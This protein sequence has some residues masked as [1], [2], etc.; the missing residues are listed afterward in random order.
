MNIDTLLDFDSL[1]RDFNRNQSSFR[2]KNLENDFTISA[3]TLES[4]EF[5]KHFNLIIRD[6]PEVTYIVGITQKQLDNNFFSNVNE[7]YQMAII[8][9]NQSE[10]YSPPFNIEE[11]IKSQILESIMLI[12]S[13]MNIGHYDTLGCL[14]DFCSD[15][16]DIVVKLHSGSICADCKARLMYYGLTESELVSAQKVLWDISKD[17]ISIRG[18]KGCPTGHKT[19]KEFHEIRREYSDRNIFLAISFGTEFQDMIDHL[20]TKF[21]DDDFDLKVVNQNI[22]NKNILCKIC[23]TI[24]ICKYGIAEFSGF[25]HNVSYEFGLMQAF[26]LETIGII[27]NEKFHEFERNMSDMKGIEVIPYESISKDLFPKLQR[28]IRL[29]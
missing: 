2:L 18:S 19:C 14:F 4:E 29:I 22:D 11:Y 23:K 20:E 9:I 1:I 27:N 24:Q 8:S 13:K 7:A 10:I 26:G 28:F 25:R 15:K 6:N 16:K 21:R 3:E 5:F 12:L 17:F